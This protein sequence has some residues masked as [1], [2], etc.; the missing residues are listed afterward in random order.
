MKVFRTNLLPRDM[1]FE[2]FIVLTLI[3]SGWIQRLAR[4]EFV[5]GSFY[6]RLVFIIIINLKKKKKKTREKEKN[7]CF[8]IFFYFIVA[9]LTK[10]YF[11]SSLHFALHFM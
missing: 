7:P 4:R 1:G 8:N 3:S 6:E 11:Q 10:K 2:H 5:Q 9:P